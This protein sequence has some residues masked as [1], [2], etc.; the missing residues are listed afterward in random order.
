MT[1][2]QVG[3]I[4]L[5]T[6]GRNL[7]LN[8][9]D[10][11]FIISGYDK[12]IAK[13]ATLNQINHKNVIVSTSIESFVHSLETPRK[14]I[15]LVP[16]GKIVDYVI[17]DLIP[18]LEKDDILIDGGNSHFTDTDR[19]FT[20]LQ[21][22]GI[23]FMGMGVSG[24][25]D[26]ARYGPSMMPG[27]NRASYEVIRPILEKIAAKA[28]GMPC[29]QFIGNGAAGHYTKMVHNGIEYAMMQMISEVYG[30]LK[31]LGYTNNELHEFFKECNQSLLKGYLIEITSAIFLKKDNLTDADLVDV[32]LDKAGQK[33]TGMWT[34][35]SAFDLLVPITIIDSAVS[36]RNISA[37]K[38]ER[39]NNSKSIGIPKGRIEIN[40]DK[41]K[42]TAMESL[43]L[44]FMLCY[45]QGLHLLQ[46]ASLKYGYQL[47]IS[48]ILDVW[49]GGCIIRSDMLG[50]FK[51]AYEKKTLLI[52]AFASSIIYN[53]I[54]V[55][56][57][58]LKELVA[59]GIQLGIATPALSNALNYCIAYSTEHL[60]ANLIQAQRDYFGAHTYERNDREG[61]FHTD[62]NN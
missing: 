35:Q 42:E 51:T 17:Q 1:K 23:H 22:T 57:T 27:S 15:I 6:M 8:I 55:R 52:N 58:E 61:I 45:T 13:Q 3:M 20:D 59:I 56:I 21:S 9:A 11:G 49:K 44:G 25:E 19:R 48:N 38:A 62:W 40:A 14:I 28:E 5:G 30:V 54:S 7:L 41:I 53:E 29:V 32:I 37:L 43:Y 16:A 46:V 2:S 10:H 47:Q 31:A 50:L 24:G 39:V 36:A 4:G 12:D 60:P 34:S 18:F 33:G 26:G